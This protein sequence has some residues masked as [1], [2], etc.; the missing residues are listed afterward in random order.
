[1][2]SNN[3]STINSL[4][5]MESSLIEQ[6]EKYLKT[7]DSTVKYDSVKKLI[8]KHNSHISMLQKLLRR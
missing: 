8:E 3:N 6:Y 5:E 7:L 1:M 2:I 4:I